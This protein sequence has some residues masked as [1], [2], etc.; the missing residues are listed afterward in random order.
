MLAEVHGSVG[1]NRSSVLIAVV[2]NMVVACLVVLHC[3]QMLSPHAD[4]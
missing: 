2:M 3:T 4:I 1:G